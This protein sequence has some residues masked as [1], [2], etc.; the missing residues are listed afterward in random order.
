MPRIAIMTW[1]RLARVYQKIDRRSIEHLRDFDLSLAQFDVLNHVGA[2]EGLT[3]QELANSLLV[4]KGNVCQLLER[5]E[6][7]G[8]IERRP[9]GRANRLFLTAAGR[10]RLTAAQPAQEA[11]IERAIAPLNPDEQRTLLDLLRKLDRALV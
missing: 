1:L 2:A 9:E 5:I 8:L 10:Q 3:Q 6:R 7:A 11:L 4:T